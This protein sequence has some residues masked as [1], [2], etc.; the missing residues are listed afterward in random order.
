[1]SVRVFV[2]I[3]WGFGFWGRGDV[4]GVWSGVFEVLIFVW[5]R[6]GDVG[7]EGSLRKKLWGWGI[8]VVWVGGVFGGVGVV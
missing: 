3:F 7:L 5:F 4:F 6:C 2:G 1:M 8:G